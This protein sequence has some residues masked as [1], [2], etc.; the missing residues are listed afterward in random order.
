MGA[1]DSC[2]K[3]EAVPRLRMRPGVIADRRSSW[4]LATRAPCSSSKRRA[5]DSNP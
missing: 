1:S 2:R 3:T 4:R 5:E